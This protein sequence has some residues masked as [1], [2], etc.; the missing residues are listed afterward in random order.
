[1]CS[2]EQVS[3]P[4]NQSFNITFD[5]YSAFVSVTNNGLIGANIAETRTIEASNQ[6]MTSKH[7]FDAG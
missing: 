2:D 3:N 4:G 1:M 6:K 7:T 5:E